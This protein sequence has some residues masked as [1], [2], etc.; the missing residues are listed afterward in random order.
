MIIKLTLLSW[1][2]R[3]LINER[4]IHHSWII[5]SNWI[6][7]RD[8]KCQ[9]VTK[10]RKTAWIVLIDI[11][12]HHTSPTLVKTSNNQND[13]RLSAGG[14]AWKDQVGGPVW[15]LFPIRGGSRTAG[16]RSTSLCSPRRRLWQAQQRTGTLSEKM[17]CVLVWL[18]RD[19]CTL[20]KVSLLFLLPSSSFPH[21][22]CGL[23]FAYC[24]TVLI[25]NFN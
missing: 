16:G 13:E 9:D 11:M 23:Q 8:V 19:V 20:R 14:G 17:S 25:I 12:N 3:D 5:G 1:R 2:V 6:Q 21:S 15:F 22:M 7:Q 18:L 4:L 24:N 10:E